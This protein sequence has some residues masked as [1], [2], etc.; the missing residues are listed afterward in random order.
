[1]VPIRCVRCVKTSVDLG[2]GAVQPGAIQ[3]PG[4]RGSHHHPRPGSTDRGHL[5]PGNVPKRKASGVRRQCAAHGGEIWRRS[6]R[7]AG[8]GGARSVSGS[9]A[10]PG[11]GKRTPPGFPRWPRCGVLCACDILNEGWDCPG[12]SRC[13]SLARPT[14]SR[15]I[16]LQQLG[17]RDAQG[18]GGKECLIVLRFRGQRQFATT[19]PSAR[20]R[21]LGKSG[22]SAWR[23]CSLGSAGPPRC[24]G[25][26]AGARGA[27]DNRAGDRPVD[28]GL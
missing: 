1:L 13:C 15:V 18:A 25:R 21:V 28:K 16:Y 6:F 9:D 7:R 27:T 4:H 8:R 23:G 11:G 26:G 24:R 12:T 5:P 14:L 20:H 3:P 19:S 22:L 17:A 2:R 10:Q